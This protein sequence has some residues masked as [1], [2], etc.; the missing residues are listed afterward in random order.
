[1][2][3]ALGAV[4]MLGGASLVAPSVASAASTGVTGSAYGYYSNI[5]LFGGTPTVCGNPSVTPC[6]NPSVSLPTTGSSSPVKASLPSEDLVYGPA[7]IFD[8]GPIQVST[9]GTPAAGSVTSSSSVSGCS[10]A[11]PNGCNAGQVYAGPFTATSVASTC[12]A[13]G[14]TAPT[15]SVTVN[16]GALQNGTNLPDAIPTNPT[17]NQ[18]FTGTNP[19]TG[20]TYK[21]VL[22]EQ[23]VNPNG[24]LT[25][26]AVHEYLNSSAKG[27]LI[28]GQ[29]V[30][31]VTGAPTTALAGTT[32]TAAPSAAAPSAAAPSV[33]PGPVA[34]PVA[35][36]ALS[37]ADPPAAA[38]LALAPGQVAGSAYGYYGNVSIFQS[39]PKVVGPTPT[40]TLPAGGSA[41]PV[42]A[43][44]ASGSVKF[45][46]AD[47]FESGSV[48]VNT[49][50][51]AASGSVTSSSKLQNVGTGGSG[52]FTA[53]Q[54][55]STCTLSGS[56]VTGSTTIANGSLVTSTDPNTGDPVGHAVISAS[57][58]PNYTV[59][60]TINNVGGSFKY[61][62]NEQIK[63]PDGSLTVNAGH[64]Y[65]GGGPNNHGPALGDLIFGQSV[66]GGAGSGTAPAASATGSSARNGGSADTGTSAG[67]GTGAA[68]SG[69]LAGTGI[70][71]KPLIWLALM[72]LASGCVAV[73]WAGDA[74][75]EQRKLPG[76][77]PRRHR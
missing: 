77:R 73:A 37:A 13:N 76:G 66:C 48:T 17:A 26:N 70:D 7:H 45:G 23:T 62:F 59:F 33:A 30:C 58:P 52:G 65:I 10:T 9:Q 55:A 27:D 74:D 5:S 57:P 46:P 8:S 31:G 24:S 40:V 32:T 4:V 34:A 43:S 56:G 69:P 39:P 38:P 50:G 14:S 35:A 12:T 75:G 42:T 67:A 44:A 72:A 51:T 11:V 2:A 54:A 25:V 63:N 16:G 21:F 36:P 1:L 71:V 6:P 19:D 28:F 53:D 68:A 15:G 18:T 22:N 61:V 49:Q 3:V 41:S 47:I 64:E 20:A 60:G 29:V